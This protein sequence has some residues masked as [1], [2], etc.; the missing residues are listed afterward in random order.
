MLS[1]L[2][3]WSL[4]LI[5]LSRIFI[6]ILLHVASSCVQWKKTQRF[7]WPVMAN[8]SNS[9]HQIL[10]LFTQEKYTGQLWWSDWK[11]NSAEDLMVSWARGESISLN[12]VW[13]L[14]SSLLRPLSH[15]HYN[16]PDRGKLGF[17]TTVRTFTWSSSPGKTTVT[18][19][20]AFHVKFYW[21]KIQGLSIWPYCHGFIK[22]INY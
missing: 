20:Q 11:H 7:D 15:S 3:K 17:L 5:H 22:T 13:R 19:K 12:P 8:S 9:I 18:A 16:T 21:F 4:N 10:T 1:V 14:N 6:W 2:L